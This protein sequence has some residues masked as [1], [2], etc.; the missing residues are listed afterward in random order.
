MRTGA[1]AFRGTSR[2]P[3]TR[4]RSSPGPRPRLRALARFTTP[5]RRCPQ[6]DRRRMKMAHAS[7][8]VSSREGF[9]RA[10]TNASSATSRTSGALFR[11]RLK[12]S[13]G[14]PSGAWLTP[15]ALIGIGE[16]AGPRIGQPKGR[17]QSASLPAR[18]QWTVPAQR[19]W[20]APISFLAKWVRLACAMLEQ[21]M[22]P[23]RTW[24]A[25]R[26]PRASVID[27]SLVHH[28]PSW[29][30]GRLGCRAPPQH[31][32]GAPHSCE[33]SATI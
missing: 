16:A 14:Q 23:Q 5:V 22:L 13:A 29:R 24:R 6:S 3:A 17:A 2:P 26:P 28:V 20:G 21:N 1:G 19:S 4:R 10:V 8:A 11:T 12:I 9:A 15:L 18:S 25:E 27:C 30:D 31:D 32:R 33:I 7:G